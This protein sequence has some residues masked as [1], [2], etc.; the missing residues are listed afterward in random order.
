[1]LWGGANDGKRSRVVNSMADRYLFIIKNSKPNLNKNEWLAL[2]AAFN[3]KKEIFHKKQVDEQISCIES[4]FLEW[5]KLFPEE[6][7][8]FDLP[9]GFVQKIK[10]MNFSEKFSIIHYIQ[11][12][13]HKNH[14][15][16][17]GI[18]WLMKN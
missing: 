9:P 3:T 1:M 16:E 11:G 14:V 4:F 17:N 13:Q 7:K 6:V 8:S 2:C 10:Q 18:D 12:F 5:E 15:G